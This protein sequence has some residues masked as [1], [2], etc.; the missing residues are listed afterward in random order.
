MSLT[1]DQEHQIRARRAAATNGPWKNTWEED[2]NWHIITGP[3]PRPKSTV[4]G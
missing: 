1:P 3:P 4:T 2:D